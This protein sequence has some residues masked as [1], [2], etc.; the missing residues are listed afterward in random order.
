[1]ELVKWFKRRFPKD[2]D[3]FLKEFSKMEINDMKRCGRRLGVINK[4]TWHI[5]RYPKGTLII[6]WRNKVYYKDDY[7][8][9]SWNGEFDT[10][11]I[12]KCEEGLT[13]S[14][15]QS[16]WISDRDIEEIM[17]KRIT[18]KYK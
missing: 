2:A 10:I 6:W 9:S 12:V 17:P 4:D 7:G 18:I 3:R 8:Q 11:G 15:H 1:M 14:G 5:D 16:I 13:A